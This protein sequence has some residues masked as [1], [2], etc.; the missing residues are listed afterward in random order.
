MQRTR[1]VPGKYPPKAFKKTINSRK[2]K[3]GMLKYLAP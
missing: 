3:W 1:F 2:L